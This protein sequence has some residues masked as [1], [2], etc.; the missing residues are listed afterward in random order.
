MKLV[1]VLTKKAGKRTV[2]SYAQCNP[3]HSESVAF[4]MNRPNV[5]RSLCSTALMNGPW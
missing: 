4:C 5:K 2:K 1:K 3:Q